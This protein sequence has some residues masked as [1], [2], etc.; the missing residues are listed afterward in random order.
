M[1]ILEITSHKILTFEASLE[2][3]LLF[4]NFFKKLIY[5]NTFIFIYHYIFIYYYFIYV[6][7]K[8]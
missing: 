4:D 8:L 2:I 7:F 5:F 1:W 6:Y 3:D